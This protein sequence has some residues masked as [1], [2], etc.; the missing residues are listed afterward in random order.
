M[1]LNNLKSRLFKKSEIVYVYKNR[2]VITGEIEEPNSFHE[3]LYAVKF[4]NGR[5]HWHDPDHILRKPDMDDRLFLEVLAKD[6]GE[7]PSA[8]MDADI[9]RLQQIAERLP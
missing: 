3:R 8:V 7:N 4:D 6:L 9:L 1:V 5:T 2:G